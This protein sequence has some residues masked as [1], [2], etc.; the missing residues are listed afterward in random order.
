[1]NKKRKFLNV[2]LS[3]TLA[4]MLCFGLMAP[5]LADGEVIT[6]EPGESL[7]A[8]ITKELKMAEGTD[9]PEYTFD[10]AA[11]PVTVDGVAYHAT[12]AYMPALEN[13]QVALGV[14]DVN[15]KTSISGGIKTVTLESGDIFGGVVWPHAGVY[16]YTITEADGSDEGVEYSGA[17]YTLTVY[18]QNKISGGT[19]TGE[20]FVYGVGVEIEVGDETAKVDPTPG[21]HGLVFTNE[22]VE[23][24]NGGDPTDPTK[25]ELEISKNVEGIYGSLEKYF[26]FNVSITKSALV[27]TETYKGYVI[28][29]VIDEEDGGKIVPTNVTSVANGANTGEKFINFPSDGT[30]VEVKLKHGQSL[31]FVDTEV[32]AKYS[33]TE[34][35]TTNYIPSVVVVNNGINNA[36]I[37][38]GVG[39]SLAASVPTGVED[40]RTE[41]ILLGAGTNSAEF[42]NEHDEETVTPTGILINNLP[43]IAIL[44]LAVGALVAFVVVK[45]R[46]AKAYAGK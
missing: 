35:G 38:A 42:T 18:V 33:V 19:P 24:G 36:E 31:V 13:L 46:K 41:I 40:E 1:M 14:G 29:G 22:Y 7:V 23:G 32:G 11:V 5:A 17:E 43:Y 44:L 27:D 21:E 15:E 6:D 39:A 25:R 3:L 30:P 26:T 37:G 4:L 2:M 10:F 28:E 20:L 8:V 16:V 45:S 12:N 9:T 34:V